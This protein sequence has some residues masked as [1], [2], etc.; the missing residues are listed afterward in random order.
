[1]RLRT[2]YLADLDLYALAA[3]AETLRAA[4]RDRALEEGGAT[5][6]QLRVTE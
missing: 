2:F 1:V 4:H 3:H 6:K 5:D